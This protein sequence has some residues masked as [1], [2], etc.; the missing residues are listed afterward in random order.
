MTYIAIISA[1][2]TYQVPTMEALLSSMKPIWYVPA[3]Q[4]EDYLKAG[5]KMVIGVEGVMPMKS[6]QLN[7]ALE[8]GFALG[9][10]VVTMDDDFQS[11]R[12]TYEIDGKLVVKPYSLK[13]AIEDLE[14]HLKNSPYHLAGVGV[15][16]NAFF[17]GVGIKNHGKIH[18]NLCVHTPN[19]VRYD[20]NL[21]ASEDT[22]YALAHHAEHGGVVFDKSLLVEFHV[23]GRNP[24]KDK[25]YDGGYAECRNEE[26][27]EMAAKIMS[28]RYGQDIDGV[29]PGVSRKNKISWKK[30]SW[31]GK[32][33]WE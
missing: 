17:N 25:L 27:A 16:L 32:P 5:A 30:V 33:S 20:E 21:G 6:K 14:K 24:N 19:V 13:L 7:R 22:E 18:G 15:S 10:T 26:T 23:F 1:K 2:R 4:K 31:A 3:D 28:E 12:K 9:E 29:K 8:D 11:V